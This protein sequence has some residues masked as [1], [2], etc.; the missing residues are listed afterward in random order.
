MEMG[1]SICPVCHVGKLR[2]RKVT[3]TQVYEGQFIVVPNVQ[4]LVCDVCGEKVF[5]NIVLGRL[6]GL[7]G[8]DRRSLGTP[9]QP[10]HTPS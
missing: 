3:Y 4:A 5:D 1:D 6:S 8:M 9:V 10:S 7:L 2:E